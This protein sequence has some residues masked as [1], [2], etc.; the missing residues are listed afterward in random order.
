MLQRLLRAQRDIACAPPDADVVFRTLADSVLSVFPAEGAIASQPEGDFVV[1]RAAVGVAGPPVGHRIPRAG[2]LAGRALQTLEGQ[3]CLDS[4]A[5]PRTRADISASTR[6]RSSI[7]VPL[8]HD[9][10]AVGLI[11]AVSS[12]PAT[13]G[14]A[15]LELLGM[16]AD[17]A[18]SRLVAALEHS[19]S[20]SWRPGPRLS[21]SR[22]PRA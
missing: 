9:G 15:D 8:V 16:L 2:T 18:S 6:T 14:E 17:V 20:R 4:Q 13:F 7:I 22:W 19:A 11:A 3:L 12:Q 10:V 5:D 21:S 1:A